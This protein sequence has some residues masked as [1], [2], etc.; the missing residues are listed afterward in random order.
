M[1]T[2]LEKAKALKEFRGLRVALTSG[3][4]KTLEKA[5]NIKRFRELRV[6]LG[7]GSVEPTIQPPVEPVEPTIQAPTQNDQDREFLQSVIDGRIDILDKGLF[8]KLMAL[9]AIYQDGDMQALV[10]DAKKAAIDATRAKYA[11]SSAKM[12]S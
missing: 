2:T 8:D 7:G 6:L 1:L 4:L 12:T 5:K 9:N 10:K 11:E 3:T